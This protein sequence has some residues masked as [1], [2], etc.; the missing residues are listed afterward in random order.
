MLC[1]TNNS[2]KHHSFV[3]SKLN[4]QKFYLKLFNLAEVICLQ[5]VLMSNISI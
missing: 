1:I 2:I 4:N 5:Q 3:Y